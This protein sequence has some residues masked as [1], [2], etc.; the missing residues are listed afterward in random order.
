MRRP[1][2]ET[3]RSSR[4]TGSPLWYLSSI[5]SS[6]LPPPRSWA[7]KPRMYP[8]RRS[9]S[10]TFSRSLEPGA[11]TADFC[12]ICPLRMRVSMSPSG[13]LIA[14][15]AFPLLPARLDHARDLAVRGQLAQRDPRQ[16]ELPVVGP[17]PPGDH[18]AVAD[19]HPRAVAGHRRQLEGRLEALLRLARAVHHDLLQLGPLRGVALHQDL[20][21]LVLLDGALLRHDRWASYFR[22][23]MPKPSRSARASSSVWAVVQMM[24]SMPRDSSTSS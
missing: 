2:F 3:R 12:A 13:S 16:T 5:E 18:A 23:G 10:S 14:I 24:T 15:G 21:V 1:G 11:F 6:R 7:S 17:R 19:P 8:S 20:A 4:I 9:T 22:N